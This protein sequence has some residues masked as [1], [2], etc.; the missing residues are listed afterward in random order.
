MKATGLELDLQFPHNSLLHIL[1]RE[2]HGN[3]VRIDF[4][5]LESRLNIRDKDGLD[6]CPQ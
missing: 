2:R 3:L 4:R 5:N 1:R 6:Y